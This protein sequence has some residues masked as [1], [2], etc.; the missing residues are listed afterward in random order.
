MFPA[1]FQAH[2]RWFRQRAS[3][4]TLASRLICHEASA[5]RWIKFLNAPALWWLPVSQCGGNARKTGN[6]AFSSPVILN[7]NEVSSR[8]DH[9]FKFGTP[10]QSFSGTG[11]STTSCS[12][13][14]AAP[15]GSLG[16]GYDYPL[17][18]QDLAVND[19][20]IFRSNLVNQAVVGYNW[21]RRD[22]QPTGAAVTLGDIGMSRS[23]SSINDLLPAFT[24]S[25]ALGA[26]GYS[27]NVGRIQHTANIT[28]R[29]TLSWVFNKHTLR[30]GFETTREQFNQVGVRRRPRA[31]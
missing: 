26:F 29:D 23:N 8:L 9:E 6:V 3:P 19:T 12:R 30:F 10:G 17:D 28:F 2:S 31:A 14:P 18:N 11:S 7:A 5:T 25:D 15:S 24:F 20:H 13:I 4:A 16:Q 22:I 27:A 1:P 21:Y